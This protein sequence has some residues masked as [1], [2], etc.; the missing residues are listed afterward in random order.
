MSGKLGES[1]TNEWK[2]SLSEWLPDMR[3]PRGGVR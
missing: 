2:M 1:M 3:R